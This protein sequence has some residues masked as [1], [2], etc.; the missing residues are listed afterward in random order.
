MHSRVQLTPL[1]PLSTPRER[2]CETSYAPR[3]PESGG[4]V[5]TLV[6]GSKTLRI[7]VHK[8]WWFKVQGFLKLPDTPRRT[9]SDIMG[10][11]A[12]LQGLGDNA[13]K[14]REKCLTYALA[15]LTVFTLAGFG[16]CGYYMSTLHNEIADLQ[17]IYN[18]NWTKTLT[19]LAPAVSQNTAVL[20]TATDAIAVLTPEV[21]DNTNNVGTNTAGLTAVQSE[22]DT[23]KGNLVVLATNVETIKEDTDGNAT[24]LT[25]VTD[26]IATAFSLITNVTDDLS[27]TQTLTSELVS[28][29]TKLNNT[30][31]S[32]AETVSSNADNVGKLQSDLSQAQFSIQGFYRQVEGVQMNLTA[33]TLSRTEAEKALTASIAQVEAVAATLKTTVDAKLSG[34]ELQ[35]TLKTAAAGTPT[36]D[37]K[38]P[39]GLPF[40]TVCTCSAG[41]ATITY[42]S[43]SEVTCACPAG[44]TVASLTTFCVDVLTS[45]TSN[46]AQV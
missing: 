24:L 46:V 25:D 27:S 18:S 8:C 43:W 39:P 3:H 38:T 17:F 41:D 34:A 2:V 33:E 30:F 21:A 42:T 28:G 20:S 4:F 12:D 31:N 23:N 11:Y 13:E 16:G 22:A 6:L 1:R 5:G 29:L 7:I 32:V 10:A 9:L 37:C 40:G 19:E 14:S 36:L 35:G 15:T 45:V 26:Q 44:D